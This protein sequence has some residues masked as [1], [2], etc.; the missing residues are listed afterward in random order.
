MSDNTISTVVSSDA[1]QIAFGVFFTFVLALI[2]YRIINKKTENCQRLNGFDGGFIP[3]RNLG[4]RNGYFSGKVTL[5]SK[6]IDYD[7]KLKDFYIKTAYNAC[8]S[9]KHKHDYIDTCALVNCA[10]H[11]VRALDFE[12]YSLNET[13]VVASSSSSSLVMKES[14]NH[15]SLSKVMREVKKHFL[16]GGN[17][18]YHSLQKDPLFLF[19]RIRYGNAKETT[20]GGDYSKKIVSFYDTVHD[21]I[22]DSLSDIKSRLHSND[23]S[24]SNFSDETN[25]RFDI[26]SDIVPNLNMKDIGGKIFVFVSVQDGTSDNLLSSRLGNIVDLVMGEDNVSSGINMYQYNELQGSNS[27]LIGEQNKNK[28]AMCV[29]NRSPNNN[30]YDI[31]KPINLGMQFIAM[32]FQNEDTNLSYYTDLFRDEKNNNASI[33]F[34]KKPQ[35]LI[36]FPSSTSRYFASLFENS[37]TT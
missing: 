30:N 5:G 8:C 3:Y 18:E 10:K 27:Y 28:L 31:R 2:V 37:K 6:T 35:N 32:N 15:L 29:P 11:G 24:N 25:N 23:Y 9:G 26:M 4:T 16:T 1:I 14:Y 34:V 7:Y 21:S 13:P 33:A 12:V 17:E 36:Y 20:D 22:V 19:F